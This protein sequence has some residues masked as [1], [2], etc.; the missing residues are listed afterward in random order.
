MLPVLDIV[1]DR[2]ILAMVTD[3]TDW[4]ALGYLGREP[5]SARRAVETTM[6]IGQALLALDA[7]GV[8]HGRLHPDTVHLDGNGQVKPGA[9]RSMSLCTAPA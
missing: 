3:W 2:G 6:A 8:H 1:P 9:R 7:E 5:M 4:P